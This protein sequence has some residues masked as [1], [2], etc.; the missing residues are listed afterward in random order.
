MSLGTISI[1]RRFCGPP[2]SGNGGYVGGRLAAFVSTDDENPAVAVRLSAPPPLDLDLD[3]RAEAQGVGLYAGDRPVA[4]AQAVPLT[5]SPSSSPSYAAASEAARRFRGFDEHPLPGCFVCG[6]DREPGDGL[7]IFPGAVDEEGLFAA[8]WT[9]DERLSAGADAA[10]DPVF[11]WAALDCPGAFSFPQVEGICLLGEIRTRLLGSVRV[12]EPCVVTSWSLENVG[13]KHVTGT[14]LHGS[15]GES[16][17][18]AR[19]V[20]IHVDADSVPRE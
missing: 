12:G 13:R 2:T 9:P 5:L 15:D 16:R 4:S 7:R 19:A 17:A 20:W 10:V 14:A 6:I 18:Y 11:V 1:E 3:V 8:P